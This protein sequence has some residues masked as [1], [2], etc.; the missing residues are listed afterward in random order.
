VKGISTRWIA[1]GVAIVVAVFAIVLATQVSTDPRAAANRSNLVGRPAPKFDLPAFDGTRVRLAERAGKT[2]VVNFWNSWCIPCR[3]E[4]GALRAFQREHARDASVDLV[5]IVRDD[6]T[7][8]ARAYAK[9]HSLNWTIASDP[10]SSVAVKFGTRGQPETYVI[11]PSGVIVAAHYG[12]LTVAEL[13]A[14]VA[15]SQGVQ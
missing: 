2:V 12:P 3:Q 4:E 9:S 1:I 15:R 11:G 7:S 14:L 8:T 6:S 13:D 5:G 10:G